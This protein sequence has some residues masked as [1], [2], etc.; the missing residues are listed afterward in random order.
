M[1][2]CCFSIK[3]RKYRVHVIGYEMI[4]Y[5][6]NTKVHAA[7]MV[8][9]IWRYKNGNRNDNWYS[10]ERPNTGIIRQCVLYGSQ[11]NNI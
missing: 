5:N 6:Y 10:S 3:L 1:F 8:I 4:D 2:S 9:V 7:K 11:K